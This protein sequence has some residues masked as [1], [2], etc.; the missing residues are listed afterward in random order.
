MPFTDDE[1]VALLGRLPPAIE[2]AEAAR[3]EA[4]VVVKRGQ[5]EKDDLAAFKCYRD[6]LDLDP[7]CKPAYEAVGRLVLAQKNVGPA[8]LEAA[9]RYFE[10]AQKRLPGDG[11]ILDIVKKLRGL[12][13]PGAAYEPALAK[14]SGFKNRGVPNTPGRPATARN[15]GGPQRTC[16]Y[17]GSPIPL[18]AESCKSCQL[19]GEILQSD[20]QAL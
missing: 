5:N 14:G 12:V 10:V 20:V 2:A 15:Q 7:A 4:A 8:G 13:S 9:V 17:C 18:G 6:A 1:L 11:A 16:E 19:S 3:S